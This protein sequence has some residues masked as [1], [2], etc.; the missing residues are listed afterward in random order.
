MKEGGSMMEF[1]RYGNDKDYEKFYEKVEMVKRNPERISVM[2]AEDSDNKIHPIMMVGD[3]PVARILL[4]EEIKSMVPVFEQS[5]ALNAIFASAAKMD[6][7]KAPDDFDVDNDG[8]D[9]RI[10]AVRNFFEW[11]FN[12]RLVTRGRE[13]WQK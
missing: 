5:W 8:K 4:A 6:V 7:R 11:Q 3:R 10:A 12:E 13:R 1:G 9:L 2:I